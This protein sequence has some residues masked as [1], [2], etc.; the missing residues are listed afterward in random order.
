MV[1]YSD[2]F[3]SMPGQTT[4]GYPV[5]YPAWWLKQVGWS[6][7]PPPAPPPPR[8]VMGAA[9]VA[10]ADVAAADADAAAAAAKVATF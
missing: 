9:D 6:E 5:G 10:A 2:G 7:G 3:L 1:Q 4:P 8:K